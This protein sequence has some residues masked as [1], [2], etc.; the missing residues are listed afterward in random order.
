M[1]A[2]AQKAGLMKRAASPPLT[3]TPPPRQCSVRRL[4]PLNIGLGCVCACIQSL[5]NNLLRRGTAGSRAAKC[6][7]IFGSRSLDKRKPTQPMDG[8]S[9]GSDLM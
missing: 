6:C 2:I 8:T 7:P 3:G 9:E 1:L 5:M 4:L